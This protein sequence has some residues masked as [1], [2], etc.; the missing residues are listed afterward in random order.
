MITA[1]AFCTAL[2]ERGYRFFSGVPC[3]HLSGPTYVLSQRPGYYVPAANEGAAVAMAAGARMAGT[4]SAVLMQNSGLGHAINPLASLVL[5]YQIPLLA[6]VSLRGCPAETDEPQHAV[7]G[8]A[9]EAIVNACGI[10]SWVLEP[11]L[12]ALAHV[13]DGVE[14]VELDRKPACVLVPKGTVEGARHAEAALEGGL[15]R[16]AAVVG[17]SRHF[18]QAAVFGT[19]GFASRELF[20]VCDRASNFYMQG[21]M[22]HALGLGLGVATQRPDRP[23]IVLDG[24]GAV[25][26]HMGTLCTAGA[27]AP[28]NLVHIVLDNGAYASTGGQPTT[29][30]VLDWRR[31][32]LANGYRNAWVCAAEPELDEAMRQAMTRPGP[33]LVAVRVRSDESAAPP[34]ATSELSPGSIRERFELALGHAV[35]GEV[36]E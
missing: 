3:S 19:T 5:P 10:P 31:L 36:E 18:G 22:G 24:D 20:A 33:N 28:P 30:R 4:R 35:T 1:E 15:S 12:D 14:S 23:V 29:S 6:F 8:T 7:M 17:A 32:A 11:S 13:L 9:T 34:R 26:M 16:T 25:L 2:L 21:S 27:L